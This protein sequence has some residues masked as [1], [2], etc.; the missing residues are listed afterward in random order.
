MNPIA[1]CIFSVTVFWFLWL[2]TNK[3]DECEAKGTVMILG[4]CVV[5]K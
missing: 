1:Y 3:Q 4:H 2:Y 5:E